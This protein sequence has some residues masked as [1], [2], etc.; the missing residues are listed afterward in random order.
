MASASIPAIFFWSDWLPHGITGPECPI[1]AVAK[2]GPHRTRPRRWPH[3]IHQE[4]RGLRRSSRAIHGGRGLQEVAG[5]REPQIYRRALQ[6]APWDNAS[7][8]QSVQ[9]TGAVRHNGGDRVFWCEQGAGSSKFKCGA[10]A[11]VSFGDGAS[12]VAHGGQ[13]VVVVGH[14]SHCGFQAWLVN[15]RLRAALGKVRS[16][17][18]SQ[19]P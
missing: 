4:V 13:T 2:A 19:K 6:R 8:F 10:R 15:G 16:S 17:E 11:Q 3:Q 7:C 9:S 1:D 5:P 18:M 14:P 12:G